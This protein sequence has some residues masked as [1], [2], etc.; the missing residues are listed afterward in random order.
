MCKQGLFGREI[1]R[2]V[3]K[4]EACVKEYKRKVKFT[5]NQHRR[6]EI[7]EYVHYGWKKRQGNK[8]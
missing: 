8:Q 7:L 4:F 2:E 5:Y 1:T 3:K 6:N